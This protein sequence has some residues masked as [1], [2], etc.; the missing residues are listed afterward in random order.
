[1]A[2]E[3][4]LFAQFMGEIK[5][6]VVESVD[7]GGDTS[8]AASVGGFEERDTIADDTAKRKAGTEVGKLR[9]LVIFCQYTCSF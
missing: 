9:I 7:D 3:D 8:D 6:T 2:D 1:M 5:N 4:E